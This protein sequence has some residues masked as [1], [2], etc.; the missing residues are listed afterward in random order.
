M[1]IPHAFPGMPVDLRLE[2][3]AI[4]EMETT[5]LVKENAFQAIR[6]VVPKGHE[7]PRHQVEGPI[8]VY[9]LEGRIAFTASGKTH[10]LKAGHWLYLLGNEPHSLVGIEDSAVLVT[11]LFTSPVD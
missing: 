11:I 7:V 3:G 8:T 9:C 4:S 5:A 2:G 1:A 6:L 10:D